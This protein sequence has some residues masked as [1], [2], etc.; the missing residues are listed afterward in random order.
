M[1]NN[2]GLGNEIDADINY[3]YTEDVNIGLSLGW[4]MP[5]N[6]FDPQNNE[7]AKQA[8]AKVGVLF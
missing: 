5:G 6:A 1:N 2:T 8:I 3:A 4:F 7:N